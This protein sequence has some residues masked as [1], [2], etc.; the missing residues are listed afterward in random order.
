MQSPGAIAMIHEN[1]TVGTVDRLVIRPLTR[2]RH[3]FRKYDIRGLAGREITVE[4]AF[5]LGQAFGTYLGAMSSGTVSVAAGRDNRPSSPELHMAVCEGLIAAGSQV[6]DVGVVPS[7]VLNFT[8]ANRQ[9]DG[10]INVTASHNPSSQNGFKL[11][12]RNAYPVAEDDIQ[13]LMA[14]IDSRNFRCGDGFLT[15]ADVRE[16]YLDAVSRLVSLKHPLRVV[17]DAGNGVAGAYAPELFRRIGAEVIE[18]FCDSD[19]NFPNHAPNPED[20]ENVRQLQYTVVEHSADVGFAYDGDGDRLGVVN[21]DGDRY[22]ADRIIIL[23]SRDFLS[24]YPGSSVLIDVKSSQTVIEDIRAY[25]GVPMIWKTGHSLIKR[26]MHQEG[27]GLAG[28]FSGHIFPAEEY[29]PIDD[30]ML[31]SGRLAEYLSFYNR[32]LSRLLGNLPER[33]ATGTI[34]IPC[35]E[36]DKFQVVADITEYFSRDGDLLTVDGARINFHGGWALVRASNTSA[37]L[38]LRF[39][40]VSEPRLREIEAL[41]YEQLRRHPAVKIS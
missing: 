16:E 2:N 21:E 27:I 10:G 17:I 40:A 37:N 5:L 35:S 31:A 26:K 36:S 33:Y 3:V 18:L 14:L 24:R 25:G 19:G 11:V 7:P 23:L 15:A 29:Y 38:T 30:A 12:S 22:D 6:I 8:V 34:E 28:E 1:T 20:P 32:P 4:L 41:V 13:R 9:L 39:E